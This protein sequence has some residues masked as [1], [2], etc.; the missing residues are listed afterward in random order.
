MSQNKADLRMSGLLFSCTLLLAW[1]PVVCSAGDP[2]V[3]E[4]GYGLSPNSSIPLTKNKRVSAESF[5]GRKKTV[6]VSDLAHAFKN[7]I[8]LK[9]SESSGIRLRQGRLSAQDA[10]VEPELKQLLDILE[11]AGNYA[12]IRMHELSEAQ[13]DAMK[14]QGEQHT[15]RALPDLNLWFYIVVNTGTDQELA[16]IINRLNQLNIVEYAAAS[17]LPAPAPGMNGQSAAEFEQ[18][19]QEHNKVAWPEPEQQPRNKTDRPS[20]PSLPDADVP[21]PMP[22]LPI[23][24]PPVADNYQAE[25]DYREAAPVG[26]DI[27][28]VNSLYYGATGWN[29]AYSDVEYSWNVN[30]QDLGKIAGSVYVNGAPDASVR[31]LLY[32]NHGTAVIGV[33]SSDD[34]GFGTI[35]LVQDAEVRLSTEL[36]ATGYNPANAI[37]AAASQF[38]K[39]SVIL[40]EMQTDAGFD[41]NGAADGGDTYVPIEWEPAAKAAITTAV[42]NGRIVVEAA[43]N[44]NCDLDQDGFNGDFNP[45]DAAKDSGAII[46]GAG[47][48][49]TRNKAS[50]STYGSRVDTHAEGDWQIYTTGYGDLYSAEGENLWYSAE[51]S[52]T[53]GASPI[54]TGA[55]VSLSSILWEYHGSFWDPKE[56]RDILR[57]DGTQQGSG[58]HIGPRPNLRKQ[59]EAMTN[60]HL[61]MHSADFD[62]DGKTD[63]AIFRPSNGRWWIRYASGV[64][65]SYPWG[66]KGDIPAPADITGD[67]R[68][69]LIVFRPGNGTWYIR[70]W[71]P[72]K[73]YKPIAWGQNGDIPVPLDYNGDGK[74]ELSVYRRRADELSQSHWYIRNWNKTTKD[75]IWG[76]V[77]DTPMARD[78][79]GDGRDDLVIFRG[80]TGEWWIRYSATG[81]SKTIAW[82]Q[83]G[84]VPLTFRDSSSRW[85]IAVWRPSDSTFYAQNI[86]TGK[87]GTTQWGQP[88][89][90]P[91]FGDTDGNGWDEY[92]V[93]RPSTGVWWNLNTGTQV[94]WGLVGDIAI[95]R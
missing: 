86:H 43:G 91:R 64:T 79:D 55:A 5:A 85:N 70:S 3:P 65:K 73:T 8:E 46:V 22:A 13:L 6:K 95:A 89:D 92:M 25:Q 68:A 40:L 18:Y 47:E 81:A 37:T 83:W 20:S 59:V 50:F 78:M 23:P 53:S 31:G 67:G 28:Y 56:M 94:Q 61:Q 41:C 7:R 4:G 58:G 84:D 44:G 9:F 32:R 30:H 72:L 27:D 60:R 29:W 52:G 17:A 66:K 49:F 54:V 71:E 75:L 87:T 69:E 51:F 93:W 16:L 11:T 39:G 15:G 33:L 76:E 35:G 77:S 19:W 88:G 26:I 36:P 42:A 34:N 48:K 80:T 82:G 74:A 2:D 63:Y 24:V 1:V 10:S 38:W 45:S 62:G 12:V 21:P 57:R 14:K 90:V